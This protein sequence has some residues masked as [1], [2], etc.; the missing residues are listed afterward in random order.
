MLN[1][2]FQITGYSYALLLSICCLSGV[3]TFHV[4]HRKAY[5]V[6]HQ[7]RACVSTT[8]YE[9]SLRVS[10]RASTRFTVG[11]VT[12][13]MSADAQKFQQ[14]MLDINVLWSGPLDLCLAAYFLYDLVG[15]E[16]T[17]AGLSMIFVCVPVRLIL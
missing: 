11:E 4:Y 15:W 2:H 3:L 12:N 1:A 10:S 17:L 7:M 14:V 9:K 8:V 16:A 13:L 5:T 6:G